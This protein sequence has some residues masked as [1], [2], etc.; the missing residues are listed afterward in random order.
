M[1]DERIFDYPKFSSTFLFLSQCLFKNPNYDPAKAQRRNASHE[2][3][4][5][6]RIRSYPT[7]LFLDEEANLITPVVGYKTPQQLE[8]YLKMFK[9]I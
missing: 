9:N 7:I 3:A 2:L 1:F 8:L 5:Y 4:Q 6:Y